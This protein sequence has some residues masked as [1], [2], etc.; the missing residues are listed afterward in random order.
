MYFGGLNG[1]NVFHP[2][3]IIDNT[4]IPPVHFTDFLLYNKP[5]EIGGKD[6]PLKKHISRTDEIIL[7]YNQNYFTIK[8]IALNF[9]FSEN[10]QYAYYMEGFEK[11]WNYTRNKTEATY[12]NMAPGHYVFK[13]K[14]SNNDGI[15]NEEGISVKNF[16]FTPLVENFMV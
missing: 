8:F 5:V 2:D 16:H 14:A 13:V 7:H 11:D 6:S 12:T 10:N 1:F 15:W 3:S 9:F 4:F